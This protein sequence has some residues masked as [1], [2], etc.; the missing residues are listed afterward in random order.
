[1]HDMRLEKIGELGRFFT[2]G[3]ILCGGSFFVPD[4]WYH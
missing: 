3:L 4:K 2:M 1:M